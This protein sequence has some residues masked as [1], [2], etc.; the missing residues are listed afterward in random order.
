[1][2]LINP[3]IDGPALYGE[4]PAGPS[5]AGCSKQ[6]RHLV[7]DVGSEEQANVDTSSESRVLRRCSGPSTAK[8]IDREAAWPETVRQEFQ[9][10][11]EGTRRVANF[12]VEIVMVQEIPHRT[13]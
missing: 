2:K 4:Y 5:V 1:M 7:S 8:V 12:V 13:L 6:L 10:F 3:S 11:V 9:V